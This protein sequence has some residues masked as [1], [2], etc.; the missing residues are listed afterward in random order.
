M[1]ITEKILCSKSHEFLLDNED[2]TYTLTFRASGDKEIIWHVFRWGDGCKILAPK[3]L[4]N[5]YK[6]YLQD[7]L[8]D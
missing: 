1:S 8:K 2:G 4:Q 7:C 5:E 6:Q 3:S